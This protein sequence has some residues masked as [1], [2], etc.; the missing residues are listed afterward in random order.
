M[1]DIVFNLNVQRALVR[2]QPV[3]VPLVAAVLSHF[4]EGV[5]LSFQILVDFSEAGIII[6]TCPSGQAGLG[7][8]V[9][10]DD[11]ELRRGILLVVVRFRVECIVD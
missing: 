8:E 1:A 5:E 11:L 7:G 9:D 6:P 4:R 10:S 3:R 2:V